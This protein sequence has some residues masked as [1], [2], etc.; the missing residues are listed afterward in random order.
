M[1]QVNGG[2]S[3]KIHERE[4]TGT[5]FNGELTQGNGHSIFD[6]YPNKVN[7]II[8]QFRTNITVMEPK[9]YF[10]S[11]L[12]NDKYGNTID[13]YNYAYSKVMKGDEKEL[14]KNL[15]KEVAKMLNFSEENAKT[16]IQIEAAC[17]VNHVKLDGKK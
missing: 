12:L 16:F 6:I 10:I 1:L 13:C 17:I 9:I 8:G 7:N 2:I 4:F 3:L 15:Y 5:W 11:V 14:I